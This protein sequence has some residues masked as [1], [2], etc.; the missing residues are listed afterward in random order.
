MFEL[1]TS[2]FNIILNHQMFQ[3]PKLIE[4]DEFNYLIQYSNGYNKIKFSFMMF[5]IIL[6]AY[7]ASKCFFFLVV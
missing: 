1:K 5:D 6:N 4:N 3:K 2:N 7:N